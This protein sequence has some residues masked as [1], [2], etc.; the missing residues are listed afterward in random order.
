MWI[1]LICHMYPTVIITV[2]QVHN[3]GTWAAFWQSCY[4]LLHNSHDS[5]VYNNIIYHCKTAPRLRPCRLGCSSAHWDLEPSSEIL[6]PGS[7]LRLAQFS[8][9]NLYWIIL[10]VGTSHTSNRRECQMPNY[11]CGSK[12]KLQKLRG[13]LLICL[14][15][16]TPSYL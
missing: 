3:S 13:L 14:K 16:G 12:S 9:L 4:A 11:S 10:N 1:S 6:F 5:V 7:K 15:R 2:L 8:F